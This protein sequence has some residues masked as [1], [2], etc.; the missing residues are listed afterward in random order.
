MKVGLVIMASGLGKRFGGNKL[1][2]ELQ[3]KPLIRWILDTSEDLFEQR[4]VVTRSREVKELCE[5]IGV[6][7]I[8]HELP[9]RSDTVRLGVNVLHDEID[10]CFFVPGDQPLLKKETLV[11][12]IEDAKSD[13]DRI[14]RAGYED[15]VGSP[16][17]FPKCFF[18][19]LMN[20]PE[21]KG[22]N[23]VAKKH[24]ELVQVVS[25]GAACELL[26]VDTQEDFAGIMEILEGAEE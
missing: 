21:G 18:E 5:G 9:F 12:L 3:G 7:Y 17:G 23:A 4:L 8:Y 20:L 24:P 2:A 22:G 13:P 15:T 10:Y 16:M 14:F 1:M 25:A 6:R 11:Q 19:D 26:D